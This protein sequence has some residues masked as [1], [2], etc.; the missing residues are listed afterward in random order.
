MSLQVGTSSS[1]SRSTACFSSVLSTPDSLEQLLFPHL[2]KCQSSLL[3]LIRPVIVRLFALLSSLI[4]FL[5]RTTPL[6][7]LSSI[8]VI[9]S[10]QLSCGRGDQLITGGA[11]KQVT[12]RAL[13]FA[14]APRMEPKGGDDCAHERMRPA[15]APEGE[16]PSRPHIY[17]DPQLLPSRGAHAF[18]KRLPRSALQDATAHV[19]TVKPRTIKLP[20]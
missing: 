5:P 20:L 10:P 2:W 9:T 7:Q 13:L 6:L 11:F 1:V 3:D 4:S 8:K 15:A 12:S 16:N 19:F 18:P 17:R 14:L